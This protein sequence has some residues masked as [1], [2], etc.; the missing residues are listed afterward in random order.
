M[1][2][3]PRHPR[4]TQVSRTMGSCVRSMWIP[5]CGVRVLEWLL[6]RLLARAFPNSDFATRFCGS[7]PVTFVRRAFIEATSGCPTV[8]A[9]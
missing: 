1:G 2:L 4:A 7:W 9:E 3:P 6:C 8:H 5:N